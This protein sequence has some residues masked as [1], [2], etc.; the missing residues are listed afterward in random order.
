MATPSQRMKEAGEAARETRAMDCS[1]TPRPDES[2]GL[3][4]SG[5]YTSGCPEEG[6]LRCRAVLLQTAKSGR[7]SAG[8]RTKQGPRSPCR[9]CGCVT[10]VAGDASED[11]SHNGQ[12]T[13]CPRGDWK[14]ETRTALVRFSLEITTVIE[15]GH[16]LTARPK[17]GLQV[18]H[19][20]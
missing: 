3:H 8:R 12:I 13:H 11:C 9:A 7:N 15:R 5:S 14:L 19:R 16:L 4:L 6:A 17:A 2:P 1:R 18:A 10:A 20:G